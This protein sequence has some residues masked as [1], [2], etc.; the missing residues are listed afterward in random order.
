M[1]CFRRGRLDNHTCEIAK[2]AVTW[3]SHSTSFLPQLKD[4]YMRDLL[5][6]GDAKKEYTFS[7][8]LCVQS[9][10]FQNCDAGEKYLVVA[11]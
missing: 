1:L 9:D 4:K 7:K 11:Y 5:K 8:W 6:A 10:C 2:I 3:H